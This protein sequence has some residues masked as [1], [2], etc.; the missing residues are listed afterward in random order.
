MQVTRNAKQHSQSPRLF[1][2]FPSGPEILGGIQDVPTYRN[3]AFSIR[4]TLKYQN[5]QSKSS[6]DWVQCELK[7]RHVGH[8]EQHSDPKGMVRSH[9]GGRYSYFFYFYFFLALATFM[10]VFFWGPNVSL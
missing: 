5:K 9:F 4:S 2:Y 1:I 3:P 8:G 10:F 7:D 6:T